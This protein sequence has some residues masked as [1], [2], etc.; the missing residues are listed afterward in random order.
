VSRH[1]AAAKGGSEILNDSCLLE[2]LASCALS[3]EEWCHRLHVRIAHLFLR[4]A[5][6]RDALDALRSA[7]Q[8]LNRSNEVPED[9]ASGYHETMT[10]AWLHL[11]WDR[12]RSPLPDLDSEA[13]CAAN[14]ELLDKHLLRSY[15]SPARIG[16]WQ[17]KRRFVEPD[18]GPLPHVDTAP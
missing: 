16:S 9:R 6:F 11:V 10:V 1:T 2:K 12:M 8:R 5:S 13:F 14:P 17:A 4:R 18:L 3:R 7:I 15:Y